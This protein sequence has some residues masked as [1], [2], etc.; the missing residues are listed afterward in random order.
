MKNKVNDE[1]K[2]HFARVP[3]PHRRLVCSTSSPRSSIITMVDLMITRVEAALA[4]RTWPS[5]SPTAANG[6]AG[7]AR[8]WDPVLGARPLRRTIQPRVRGP[9]SEK[10]L[11]G[12]VQPGQIV[13]VDVEGLDAG[14]PEGFPRRR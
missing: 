11:F 10:I 12:E 4:T 2:K 8:G 9:L 13:I 7:P 5:S 3:Q 6:P 14:A 1:L